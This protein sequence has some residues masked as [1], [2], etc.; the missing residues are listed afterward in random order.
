MDDTQIARLVLYTDGGCQG[1]PGPG[2]WAAV[3]YVAQHAETIEIFGS[4]TQTTNNK[5]ELQGVIE[6]LRSLPGHY[7]QFFASRFANLEI[8]VYTDSQ[9][10]KNGITSW[11]HKW[12]RNNWRTSAKKTVK[13]KELWQALD[14]AVA[15]IEQYG[16]LRWYWVKGHAGNRYNE[17]CDALVREN[18]PR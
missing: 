15:E 7:P 14:L 16:R 4:A 18:F 1:N 8:S 9:Y 5:M 11:I 10:V 17:R 2:A 13:N 6:G 3:S 12:K